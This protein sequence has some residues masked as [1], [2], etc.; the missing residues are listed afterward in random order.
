[1]NHTEL[2]EQLFTAFTQGD[3]DSVRQLC[4]P[5]LQAIQNGGPPMNLETLIGF[6]MAV[7]G[8][9]KDFRY[10]DAHRSA[11]EA[12]FVE[13][14]MVRG[15]LPDGSEFNIAACVIGEIR[16]GKITLLREYVDSAAA[17]GLITALSP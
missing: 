16:D 17:A 14:H 11:T 12:G 7:L 8:V 15:T 6:T 1:M 3:E 13:G 9:V 4:A 10:E 2:C 5:D